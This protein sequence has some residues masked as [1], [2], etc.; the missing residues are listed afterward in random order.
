[1]SAFLSAEGTMMNVHAVPI[2]S[3]LFQP[4]ANHWLPAHEGRVIVSQ[5]E[6]VDYL[7]LD[8]ECRLA[9][10]LPKKKKVEPYELL[11]DLLNLVQEPIQE[12]N[13]PTAVSPENLISWCEKYGMILPME[14]TP[15]GGEGVQL[16][17]A[18]IEVLTL[19]LIYHLWQS[20]LLPPAP[21]RDVLEQEQE[22]LFR[23]ILLLLRRYSSRNIL[24]PDW[25]L[26]VAAREYNPEH[27]RI[28]LKTF[29]QEVIRQRCRDLLPSPVLL[30]QPPQLIMEAGCPLTEA[31]WQLTWLM[32]NP[33][34]SARRHHLCPCGWQFYGHANRKWCPRC[35]RRTE[36]S[37]K[38]RGTTSV[39]IAS[40]IERKN[41]RG[42]RR[43]DQG[44]GA[45]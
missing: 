45:Q 30:H 12:D 17:T 43:T 22:E 33:S 23:L 20:V 15:N 40:M 41:R 2:P 35:D 11:F 28:L 14:V 32:L 42:G 16:R 39:K 36:H 25:T 21:T 7:R 4:L 18:Q 34:Y 26:R 29:L 24:S 27:Q 13:P 10:R 1:M 3:N 8:G 44:Q 5:Y 37:R 6:G 38:R 9:H 19:Y 31:Y